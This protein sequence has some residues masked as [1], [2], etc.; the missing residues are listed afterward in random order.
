MTLEH[1]GRLENVHA[2]VLPR[3]EEQREFVRG[4]ELPSVILPETPSMRRA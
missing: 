2:F 4:L 3:T 1:L